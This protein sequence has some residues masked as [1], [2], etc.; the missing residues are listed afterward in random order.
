[1][2]YDASMSMRYGTQ[3]RL[4]G[5]EL[6]LIMADGRKT[7]PLGVIKNVEIEISSKTIPVYFFVLDNKEIG[8][9]DIILGRPFLRL[10]Q[11]V[12]DAGKR[13]NHATPGRGRS[14]I[15]I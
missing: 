12:L 7:K 10:V 14:A 1:M 5:T 3:Q 6:E 15:S 2:T 4:M 9:G 8:V 13:S 11:P